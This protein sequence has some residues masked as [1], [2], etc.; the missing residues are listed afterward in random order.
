MN[1]R[2]RAKRRRPTF[3]RERAAHLTYRTPAGLLRTVEL[4]VNVLTGRHRVRAI[5]IEIPDRDRLLRVHE[6]GQ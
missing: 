6:E 5:E 4:R 3:G 1:S 2:Q